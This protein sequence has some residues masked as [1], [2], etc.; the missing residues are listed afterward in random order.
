MN[1]DGLQFA[2]IIY[3]TMG[4]SDESST[5]DEQAEKILYHY[6]YDL[7]TNIQL[8]KVNM[9]EGLI[10]FSGK[11]SSEPLDVVVMDNCSWAFHEC[12]LDIWIIVGV[13][14]DLKNNDH[15]SSF[16][17]HRPNSFGLLHLLKRLQN[18]IYFLL[19]PISSSI[20]G[21]DDVGWKG[22]ESIKTSRKQIR[23]LGLKLKQLQQDLETIQFRNRQSQ[24]ADSA[25]QGEETV[26]V[27]SGDATEEDV[28]ATICEVEAEIVSRGFELRGRLADDSSYLAGGVRRVLARF[29]KFYLSVSGDLLLA[30]PSLFDGLRGIAYSSLGGVAACNT[31]LIRVRQAVEV[32]GEAYACAGASL[33]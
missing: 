2:F 11:F 31:A 25:S 4:C 33:V 27:R 1:E 24:T 8:N 16:H 17:S 15:H 19:G 23:K 26:G 21:K 13:S 5:D 20:R 32:A 7:S 10:E 6:P 18:R 14:N 22:L 29:M 3:R 30:T 9:L 12:E 28:V